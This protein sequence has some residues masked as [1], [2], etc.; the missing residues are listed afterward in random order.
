[1]PVAVAVPA[2]RVTARGVAAS[3]MSDSAP[4]PEAFS[5]RTLNRYDVPSVRP[6]SV[7]D[8]AVV[9]PEMSV[10]P[11]SQAFPPA[12]FL[13]C[14]LVS[15]AVPVT[16]AASRTLPPPRSTVAVGFVGFPGSVA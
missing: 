2:V 3:E 4:K 13:Y 15:V 12:F 16:V 7:C 8:S 6:V 11:V 1:M 14:H 10:H 5:A 9:V